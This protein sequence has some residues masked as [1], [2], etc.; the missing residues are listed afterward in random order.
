MSLCREG[1]GGEGGAQHN[2][3]TGI[4]LS[5]IKHLVS[6]NLMTLYHHLIDD[7]HFPR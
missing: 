4:F 6:T 3:S 2:P 7:F 1:R 5:I